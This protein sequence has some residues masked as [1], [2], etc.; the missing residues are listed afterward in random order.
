MN[1]D[2]L[3]DILNSALRRE[4][5]V[6]R[7]DEAAAARVLMRFARLPRQKLSFRR[8]PDVLLDWQF[9]PAWPRM[10]ALAGC[11]AIGFAIG[12]AGVDRAVSPTASPYSFVSGADFDGVSP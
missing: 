11:A 2:R 12:L 6:S 10:A 9:A 4:T 5:A 8:L 3:D 7:D 1:N